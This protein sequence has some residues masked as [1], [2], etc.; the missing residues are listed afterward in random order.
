MS[1]E[2]LFS[3]ASTIAVPGWIIL[4]LAPRRWPWLNAMPPLGIPLLL[5]AGYAALV[6]RGFAQADGGFGS[7]AE[8]RALLGDDTMLLAGWVHYLAFDLIAGSLAA[9]AMDRGAVSRLIQAPIL[10]LIFLLGPLGW[11][12]AMLLTG[13]LRVASNSGA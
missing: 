3:I 5:S 8:V 6:M 1:P 9:T 7:L 11:L 13:G 2:T 12:L 4:I 10:L